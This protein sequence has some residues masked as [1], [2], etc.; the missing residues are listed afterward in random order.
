MIDLQRAVRDGEAVDHQ[1]LQLAAGA[2]AVR[3]GRHED[4]R[5]ERR[6]ARRDLSDVQVPDLGR[7]ADAFE[8][9][10]RE[11]PV[12][13]L[14]LPSAALDLVCERDHVAVVPAFAAVAALASGTVAELALSLPGWSLDVQ[15]AYRRG[16][17][18]TAGVRV[19]RAAEPAILAP[20]ER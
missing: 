7:L 11:H 19:L 10:R 2:V 16:S 12:H 15:L 3:L 4:M 13:F 14:G 6:E 20:L 8:L 17:A 18:S 9:R 1:P 5:R